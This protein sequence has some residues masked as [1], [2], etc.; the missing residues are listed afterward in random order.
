[1]WA[2][3]WAACDLEDC[4]PLILSRKMQQARSG[5]V[6]V[7][8][9]DEVQVT[10]PGL[11]C[12][13]AFWTNY[14]QR[15]Q[16]DKAKSAFVLWLASALPQCWF[17]GRDLG[18]WAIEFREQS[19]S[20]GPRTDEECQ[21]L[22]E[23][24]VALTGHTTK[25]SHQCIAEGLSKCWGLT[26]SCKVCRG[27]LSGMVSD[28]SDAIALHLAATAS[29]DALSAMHLA[30]AKRRRR[31]DEDY[32]QALLS[33]VVSKGLALN[34]AAYARAVQDVNAKTAA[35]W[36]RRFLGWYQAAGFRAFT[37]SKGISLATDA[38]RVGQPGQE[39]LLT[40][41]FDGDRNVGMWL[42][43][44]VPGLARA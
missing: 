2:E 19:C 5:T 23:V 6:E 8:A 40:A 20:G 11:L 30:G 10:T 35:S 34:T 15:G 22:A 36:D 9:K 16:S 3:V 21:H 28:L 39:M 4:S 32:R 37:N 18:D 1:M 12:I 31:M 25:N 26:G 13:F 14:C 17:D 43:P 41:I 33:Q 24:R 42:P 38:C 7:D 29:A 27:M 44:Q